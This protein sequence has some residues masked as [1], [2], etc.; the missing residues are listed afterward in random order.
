MIVG[1]GGKI[2]E[3]GKNVGRGDIIILVYAPDVRVSK[4]FKF[5]Q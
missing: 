2:I 3:G 1:L 5:L 4:K